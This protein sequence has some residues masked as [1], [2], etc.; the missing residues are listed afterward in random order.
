V[1][2]RPAA[3]SDIAEILSI[4][5]SCETAAHWSENEYRNAFGAGTTPRIVLIAEEEKVVGFVVV[6][7]IAPEW[8][9][10]NVA[11][12]AA[13]RG[14]GTGLALVQ[15]IK[16]QAQYRHA[17]ALT[18]EVRAS[19]AAARALYK[20]AGFTEAGIR[21]DYY[22]NPPEDAVVY[23]FDVRSGLPPAP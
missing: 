4:E 20:K 2:I 7:T 8:D 3:P 23:R 17:D 5:R 19:N 6:R 14:R 18:L 10:E 12:S 22:A 13:W 15:A 9:I 11:V 21:R 1:N 16:T